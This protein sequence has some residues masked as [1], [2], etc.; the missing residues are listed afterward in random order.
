MRVQ[1]AILSAGVLALLSAR[2]LAAQQVIDQNQP[3]AQGAF[4]ALYQGWIGQSFVQ[5]GANVSGIGLFMRS[6]NGNAATSTIEYRV[7]DAVPTGGN[8]PTLLRSGTESITLAANESRWID[9]LFLP[10]AISPGSSLF[11]AVTGPS[12][13]FQVYDSFTPTGASY[14][15]GQAY[16]Q[17]A[18]GNQAS[19]GYDL[20]FRTWTTL[21]APVA[22]PEPGS[23]TLLATGL[24]GIGG[25]IR[26][27][28]A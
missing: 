13:G 20:T 5:S 23:L 11:F 19:P 25:A 27:R 3:V 15:S 28:R 1:S 7:Y 18:A 21:A 4:A 17:N 10:Y 8:A 26:R 16:L 22:A 24:I 14:A 9:L 2:P 6:I 12:A